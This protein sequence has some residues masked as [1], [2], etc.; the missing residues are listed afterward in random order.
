M[1]VAYRPTISHPSPRYLRVLL[2]PTCDHGVKRVDLFRNKHLPNRQIHHETM[3]LR[4]NA[5]PSGFSLDCRLTDNPFVE[6]SRK[7]FSFEAPKQKMKAA[8]DHQIRS[9]WIQLVNPTSTLGEKPTTRENNTSANSSILIEPALTRDVLSRID[10]NQYTLIEVNS[11]ANP[12]ICKIVSRE[13]LIQK[14]RT[15]I[16]QKKEQQKSNRVENVIKEIQLTWKIDTNDLN[17][18]LKTVQHCFE[19]SYKV[20]VII[21]S[22]RYQQTDQRHKD[23]LLTVIEEQLTGFGGELV[24]Q[25]TEGGKLIMEWHPINKQK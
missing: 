10:L 13:A 21:N 4:T 6:S 1:M 14:E 23:E 3:L 12:P 2:G 15:K 17:H 20:R 25:E 16:K 18:K 7:T 24:K 9:E 5:R 11:K 22:S 19:K 8:S